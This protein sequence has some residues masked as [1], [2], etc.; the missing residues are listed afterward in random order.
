MIGSCSYGPAKGVRMNQREDP[1]L[2][3]F[4]NDP[5]G[6]AKTLREFSRSAEVLSSDSPR[7]IDKH[8]MQWIGVFRGEVSAKAPNLETLIAKLKKKGIPPGETIV[9]FVERNQRTLIL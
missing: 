7:L 8:P 2:S 4:G 5:K 3:K 1:I 6:L 9:R